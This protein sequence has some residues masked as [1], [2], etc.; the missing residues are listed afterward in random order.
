MMPLRNYV[1]GQPSQ[2]QRRRPLSTMHT[3]S[4]QAKATSGQY[5]RVPVGLAS[6]YAMPQAMAD[7]A[8]KTLTSP[9]GTEIGSTLGET[10]GPGIGLGEAAVG[11]IESGSAYGGTPAEQVAL[12]AGSPADPTSSL[13][14]RGIM[15]GVQGAAVAGSEGI[16][17]GF[18]SGALSLPSLVATG[19]NKGVQH[20]MNVMGTQSEVEALFSAMGLDPNSTEAQSLATAALSMDP[21]EAS[22]MAPNVFAVQQAMMNAQNQ[23][24]SLVSNAW[25]KVKSLFM[26][27]PEKTTPAQF[28][29]KGLEPGSFTDPIGL[30]ESGLLS[31]PHEG[32]TEAIEAG[33]ASPVSDPM[34]ETGIP[35]EVGGIGTVG[36]EGEGEGD[37]GTVLCT[38]LYKQNLISADI[39][40]ADSRY[41]QGLVDTDIMRGYLKW[42]TP[43]ADLMMK[44]KIITHILKPFITKW[45]QHIAYDVSNGKIG[46]PSIF[47]K[48]CK[49][50][51][52]PLCALIGRGL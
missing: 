22:R 33:I 1:F 12:V 16:L 29:I 43:L 45:A 3:L 48:L 47:G 38:A 41:G 51:G 9:T 6:Y 50:I 24:A 44:S 40:D 42:A 20:V 10:V 32:Y 18:V 14:G 4:R 5:R 11:G 17:P 49:L 8:T 30:V 36:A 39:Y 34:G 13:L 7:T 35:G 2:P 15:G 25:N 27:K 26:S 21:T 31:A 52:Q 37:G 23:P 46:N 28:G 19:I